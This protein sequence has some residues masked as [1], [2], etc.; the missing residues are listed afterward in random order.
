MR[1]CDS[2]VRPPRISNRPPIS[3]AS[4]KTAAANSFARCLLDKSVTNRTL[5]TRQSPQPSRPLIYRSPRTRK[6]AISPRAQVHCQ[7]RRAGLCPRRLPALHNNCAI[8]NR[9]LEDWW[10]KASVH[11]QRSSQAN[12]LIV[13]SVTRL[14]C[15][16]LFTRSRYVAPSTRSTLKERAMRQKTRAALT[17][18]PRR[19]LIMIRLRASRRPLTI[20]YRDTRVHSAVS[21]YAAEFQFRLAAFAQQWQFSFCVCPLRPPC[22]LPWSRS[23]KTAFHQN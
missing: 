5:S 17:E 18:D 8:R 16:L 13:H 21:L 19:N 1:D 22:V 20:P 7:R 9:T 14:V 10:N 3:P 23:T 11:E 4:T 6:K 2:N 12:G 15:V